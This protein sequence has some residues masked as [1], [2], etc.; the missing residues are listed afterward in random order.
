MQS[1]LGVSCVSSTVRHSQNALLDVSWIANTVLLALSLC[2]W[3][4]GGGCGQLEGGGVEVLLCLLVPALLLPK[5]GRILRLLLPYCKLIS[6]LIFF[7]D[8]GSGDRC[9]FDL[10]H[11]CIEMLRVRP[12]QGRRLCQF[13]RGSSLLYAT[14]RTAA[15]SC[16]GLMWRLLCNFATSVTSVCVAYSDAYWRHLTVFGPRVA[17]LLIRLCRDW[18]SPFLLTRVDQNW[19]EMCISLRRSRLNGGLLL[20]HFSSKLEAAWLNFLLIQIY[21]YYSY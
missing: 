20:S 14:Y 6:K 17:R 10:L 3:R 11:E 12:L 5:P 21:F 1:R 7:L 15:N 8:L 2:L 4:E 13:F 9:I 16:N 18:N 19:S